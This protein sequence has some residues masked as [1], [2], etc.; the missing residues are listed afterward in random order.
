MLVAGQANGTINA[1]G[2]HHVYGGFRIDKEH[3]HID[4][5][6]RITGDRRTQ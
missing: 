5:P 6:R 3:N 2:H 1:A 4:R